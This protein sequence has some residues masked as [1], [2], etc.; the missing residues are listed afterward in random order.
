MGTTR[1]QTKR[2][3]LLVSA[4]LL[5]LIVSLPHIALA[6][7]SD[8]ISEIDVSG[9]DRLTNTEIT[10]MCPI[11]L[12]RQINRSEL[13]TLLA[14]LADTDEFD[15]I[16]LD[17]YAGRLRISVVEKTLSKGKISVGLS[18]SSNRGPAVQIEAIKP[19]LFNRPLTGR[20]KVQ[21]S[22]ESTAASIILEDT[23][24][25][26]TPYKRKLNLSFLKN[27]LDERAYDDKR[28]RLAASLEFPV[29]ENS[30]IAL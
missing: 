1:F 9:N 8:I 20:I 27:S 23:K 18:V 15:A 28:T 3:Q 25:L 2:T 29:R 22:E 16:D 26:G 30:K 10:S 6:R 13:E 19:M 4:F 7:D 5:A 12:G 24:F 17:T 11:D 14:C 21:S